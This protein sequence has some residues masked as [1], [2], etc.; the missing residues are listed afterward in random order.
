MIGFSTCRW[1]LVAACLVVGM[2]QASAGTDGDTA[3]RWSACPDRAAVPSAAQIECG[4]L[5]TGARI[6]G[7]PVELRFAVLR[8]HPDRHDP[9]PI[10]HV[11]GGPGESAGLDA[12][13]LAGWQ[14]WQQRVGWRHDIVLF[15]PRGT[16]DSRPHIGCSARAGVPLR[17]LPSSQADN[18]FAHDAEVIQRCLNRLGY[19]GM[20]SLGP[21]AQIADM[22]ALLDGLGVNRATVW[23]VSYGTRI[24][25]LFARRYPNRVDRLVLDSVV[26]FERNEL[27]AL[28]LQID[29]AIQR[30]ED[31]CARDGDCASGSPRQAIAALLSRYERQP[32]VVAL[33]PYRGLPALF[34]ITPYR[35]L[36]M[37]L[38]AA[39]DSGR[40]QGTVA[41]IERALRG[42]TAALVPL[43]ARV[44]AQGSSG[45]RSAAT[46]WATRCALDDG[47][48]T[49]AQAWQQ[50]LSATPLIAPYIEQAPQGSVCAHWPLP[51]YHTSGEL[52]PR[53][54]LVLSGGA[55]VLTPP[56][57]GRAFAAV[58]RSARWVLVEDAGHAPTLSNPDAGRVVAEFLNEQGAR[59]RAKPQSGR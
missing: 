36:L 24:A 3:I 17:S 35:L 38:F 28:P 9:N 58:H 23:G 39:Y 33:L 59:L 57:W 1:L 11:P 21:A 42:E 49:T 44:A 25:L 2:G 18:P 13:G 4:W 30:L 15:D 5:E 12:R 40:E 26:P 48:A 55:D 31:V 50:I 54:M 7:V 27:A 32:P 6:K 20:Q 53:P 51:R 14:R 37:V 43:A 56:A 47:R 10:I 46:F 22:A 41:R 8:A 34:E 19:D 16:G 29:G 52:P 45:S